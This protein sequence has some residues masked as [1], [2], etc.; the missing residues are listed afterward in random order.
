M[1]Y[2]ALK[3][4]NDDDTFAIHGTINAI[5]SIVK[6]FE[7]SHILVAFD[8]GKSSFRVALYSEYKVH[9]RA[10]DDSERPPD[11]AIDQLQA[12][13][14]LLTLF[15]MYVHRE[16]NTEADDIIANCV[17][18]Y[19]NEFYDVIIVSGDKDLLQLVSDNVMVSKPAL[20]GKTGKT[21]ELWDKRRVLDY[22]GQPPMMLPEIWALSGDPGDGVPG[23]P[24]IGEKTAIKLIEKYGSASAVALS[25]EKK[26]VGHEANI[27]LSRKL[28]ELN[29]SVARC[30]FEL[31]DLLWRP[32]KPGEPFA[33]SLAECLD[34]FELQV[35][36]DRWRD[37]SL[38]RPGVIGRKRLSTTP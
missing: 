31:D 29:G 35:L 17:W 21:E 6:K 23:V 19:R 10:K 13:R 32:T 16:E 38:W 12:T 3:N 4:E 33:K 20:G 26:V 34:S 25:S 30:D 36:S 15:G 5:A 2:T 22:Y 14:K 1:R 37:G 24:G 7:P 27:S 28:V 8:N 11:D 18:R 9:R